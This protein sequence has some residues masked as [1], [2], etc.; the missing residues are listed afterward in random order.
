MQGFQISEKL[1]AEVQRLIGAQAMENLALIAEKAELQE[2]VQKLSDRVA[3][4]SAAK[5]DPE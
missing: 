4:M 2:A 1:L 3:E 5:P